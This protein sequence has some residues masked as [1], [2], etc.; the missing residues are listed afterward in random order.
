MN[1]IIWTDLGRFETP[2]NAN[3]YPNKSIYIAHIREK[4]GVWA[5]VP[6][7]LTQKLS[8]EQIVQAQ[9]EIWIAPEAIKVVSF[10]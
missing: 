8:P 9:G 7:G 10:A 3:R 2:Y 4:E 1:A 5:H 6:E